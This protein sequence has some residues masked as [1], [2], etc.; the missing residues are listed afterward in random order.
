MKQYP[1]QSKWSVRQ[2]NSPGRPLFYS[3][4]EASWIGHK[5]IFICFYNIIVETE[6]WL[7]SQ[8]PWGFWCK[9]LHFENW[10][11]WSKTLAHSLNGTVHSVKHHCPFPSSGFKLYMSGMIDTFFLQPP[12]SCTVQ[13]STVKSVK[14]VQLKLEGKDF[15]CPLCQLFQSMVMVCVSLPI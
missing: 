9:T 13:P 8:V 4:A 6:Q 7:I 10:K 1:T 3:L 14:G 15:F 11:I 12:R 5:N 2:R